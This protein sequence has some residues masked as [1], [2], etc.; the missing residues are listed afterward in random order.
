MD[1][2]KRLLKQ[3]VIEYALVSNCLD[4]IQKNLTG[5]EPEEL[6]KSVE[7]MHQLQEQAKRTDRLVEEALAR[8][9]PG[10]AIAGLLHRRSEMMAQILEKNRLIFDQ[11]SGIL[12]A[13]AAE[14]GDLRQG[15]TAMSGYRSKTENAGRIFRNSF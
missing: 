4:Q 3:S 15:Q 7:E 8:V 10:E 13:K 6:V 12:A 11:T 9:K 5:L 2:L 14:M 1:D